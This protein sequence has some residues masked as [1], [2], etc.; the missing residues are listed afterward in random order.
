[1]VP[2]TSAIAATKTNSAPSGSSTPPA[3]RDRKT[4]ATPIKPRANPS[5]LTRVSRSPSRIAAKTAAR[6]GLV[7]NSI[8]A[9]PAETRLT[10]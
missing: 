9:K 3:S 1:M 5:A 8:A 7:E 4:I 2:P 10:P 6:I